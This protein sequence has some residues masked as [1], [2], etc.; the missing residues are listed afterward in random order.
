MENDKNGKRN[1][2]LINEWRSFSYVLDQY[3]ITKIGAEKR[4]KKTQNQFIELALKYDYY[5]IYL[6]LN[7][8]IFGSTVWFPNDWAQISILLFPTTYFVHMVF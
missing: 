6:S 3:S 5:H 7:E 4:K 1:L 2:P 8:K